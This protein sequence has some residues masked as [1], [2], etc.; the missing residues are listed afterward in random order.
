VS[1]VLYSVFTEI[2]NA[3]P[4]NQSHTKPK[5]P[6]YIVSLPKFGNKLKHKVTVGRTARTVFGLN[7]GSVGAWS[8]STTNSDL[9]LFSFLLLVDYLQQHHF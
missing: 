4:L 1:T 5:L 8:N 7:R 6:K 9:K 3:F 2:F